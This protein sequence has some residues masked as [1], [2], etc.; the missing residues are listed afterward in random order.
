[1]RGQLLLVDLA[2]DGGLIV[3]RLRLPTEQTGRQA[4]NF[5]GECQLRA[6]QQTHRH[7]KV[8]GG[9]EPTRSGAEI[10]RHELVA[11]FR[12][13]RSHTLEAKVTHWRLLSPG[14]VI[15]G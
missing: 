10:T 11:D 5:A 6:G 1:M 7:T 2:E 14:I 8:I 9:G 4:R 13:S 15:R 12:G 3:D